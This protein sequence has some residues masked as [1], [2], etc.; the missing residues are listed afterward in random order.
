MRAPLRPK[1]ADVIGTIN[2]VQIGPDGAPNASGP[3]DSNF[4]TVQTVINGNLDDSNIASLNVSKLAGGANDEMLLKQ[5]GTWTPKPYGISTAG[6]VNGDRLVYDSVATE[7]KLEAS[8]TEY[9]E[10][11]TDYTILQASGE[12]VAAP[13]HT[14]PNGMPLWVDFYSSELAVEGQAGGQRV[15]ITLFDDATQLGNMAFPVNTILGET[16]SSSVLLRRRVVADG[17]SQTWRIE[18]SKAFA[19]GGDYLRGGD[20]ASGNP[21][22]MFIS[23]RPAEA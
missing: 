3:V 2:L 19:S 18:A 20:G 9:A 13:A 4:Q 6:A 10:R 15:E 11:T 7:W 14:W 21:M 1:E 5:S 8:F 22:P 23:V 17:T 16:I 12:V